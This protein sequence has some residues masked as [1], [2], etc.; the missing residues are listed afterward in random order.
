MEHSTQETKYQGSGPT[1][2]KHYE[3]FDGLKETLDLI[4]DRLS[5]EAYAGHLEGNVIKYLMRHKHKNGL[6]DLKK[7]QHY[8][9][10]LISHTQQQGEQYDR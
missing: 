7:A 1:S 5:P 2:P 6:E 3:L 8:L 10:W 4:E 9:E